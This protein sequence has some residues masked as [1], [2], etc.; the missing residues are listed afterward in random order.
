MSFFKHRMN[1][2]K[3]NG[4]GSCIASCTWYIRKDAL[5]YDNRSNPVPI[6]LLL[7]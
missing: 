6:N 7:I 1:R 2:I 3:I 5:N 4:L